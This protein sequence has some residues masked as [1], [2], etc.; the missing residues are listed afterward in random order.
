MEYLVGRRRPRRRGRATARLPPRRAG[1]NP[2]LAR[3]RGGEG[4]AAPWSFLFR[5]EPRLEHEDAPEVEAPVV[6]AGEV[7]VPLRADRGRV[8]QAVL[9]NR[10]GVEQRL[11]PVAQRGAEPGAEG[12][13]EAHLGAV[14]QR[15]GDV[16]AED[17]AEQELAFAVTHFHRGREAPG[18]FDEAVVEER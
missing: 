8:E 9:P 15:G 12:D 14:D 13:A 11:G 4:A 3:R 10:G 6:A 7:L 18:E 2:H 16:A 5:F 17:A 1:I